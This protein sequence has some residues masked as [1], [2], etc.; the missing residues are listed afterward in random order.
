MAY[1]ALLATEK[2]SPPGRPRIIVLVD[3]VAAPVIL[4][5]FPAQG[6]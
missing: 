3:D 5:Q 2:D 6:R 4:L 1:D